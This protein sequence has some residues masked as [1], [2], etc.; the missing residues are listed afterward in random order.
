MKLL[1]SYGFLFLFLPR[2]FGDFSLRFSYLQL[3]EQIIN[4]AQLPTN[5][6]KKR[7][8]LTMGRESSCENE[9]NR[10]SREQVFR[11]CS[12]YKFQGRL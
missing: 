6:I 12:F 2:T 9:N 5:E 8:F 4:S 7:A 11:F 1:D 10:F 3:P